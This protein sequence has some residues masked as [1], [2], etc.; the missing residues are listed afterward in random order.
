VSVLRNRILRQGTAGPAYT[1]PGGTS[2]TP[3]EMPLAMVTY[4]PI[5]SMYED[6]H[7]APP[8]TGDPNHVP[9]AVV[10]PGTFGKVAPAGIV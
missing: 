1:H 2:A 10:A 3:M 9:L 7:A 8:A 4:S 5:T 6:L